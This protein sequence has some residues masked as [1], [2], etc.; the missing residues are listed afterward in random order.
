MVSSTFG[1]RPIEC[2]QIKTVKVKDDLI[3]M[4]IKNAKHTDGRSFGKYRTIR[5]QIVD[6]KSEEFEALGASYRLTALF[7]NKSK[8][9]AERWLKG[10]RN[11]LNQL[12]A[13]NRDLKKLARKNRITLYSGR[14]QFSANAK[15]A[16]VPAIEIA[17]MMGHGSDETHVKSY[18]KRRVGS[19]RFTI[20]A[21]PLDV[22]RVEERMQ[23]KQD[24]QFSQQLGR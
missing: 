24:N 9:E 14:H 5:F 22:E 12:Y 6:E 15:Q 3:G 2:A 23:V 16:G 18:G 13:K 20:Q 17:A 8:V 4:K 19:G 21:D 1:L 10:A 11:F 7:S